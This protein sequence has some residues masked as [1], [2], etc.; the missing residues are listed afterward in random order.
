M[1]QYQIHLTKVEPG[2]NYFDRQADARGECSGM[3]GKLRK[4]TRAE[5]NKNQKPPSSIEKL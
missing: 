3:R 1:L 5:A 4:F 2:R